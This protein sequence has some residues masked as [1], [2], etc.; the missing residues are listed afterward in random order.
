MTRQRLSREQSREQTRDRLL[1]AAHAIFT[2][3]GFASA[4]VEDIAAAAGYTRG[5]F[6][7]NFGGKTELFFE[8]LRRESGEIN[9]EF[10]RILESSTDKAELEQK[11]VTYYSALYRDK[12]SSLLWMEAKMVAIRDTRFRTKF[13]EFLTEKR[14]QITEFIEIFSALTG[15]VLAAPPE[16]MAVGLLALCDGV[17]SAHRC[18]PQRVNDQTAEAVMSW[19]MRAAIFAQPQQ[20]VSSAAAATALSLAPPAS[21]SGPVTPGG[22]KRKRS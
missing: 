13:N 8:L 9:L 19:F 20:A 14:S 5:A 7:S 3:K 10:R 17:S 2:K 4:S 15:T 18:D 12:M 1:E 22:A 6:Y 11:I 16:Q 21:R